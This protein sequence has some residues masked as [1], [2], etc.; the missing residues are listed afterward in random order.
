MNPTVL[1][2]ILTAIVIV[3]LLVLLVSHVASKMKRK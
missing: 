2:S 1:L 3:K